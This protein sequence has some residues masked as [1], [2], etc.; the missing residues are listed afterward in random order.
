MR[1]LLTSLHRDLYSILATNYS[2]APT[3][4]ESFF[5]L[6][7]DCATITIQNHLHLPVGARIVEFKHSPI[8]SRSQL[9]KEVCIERHIWLRL[10]DPD[11]SK[12]A[13]IWS[14]H[15]LL[16]LLTSIPLNRTTQMTINAAADAFATEEEMGIGGWIQIDNTTFWFSQFWKRSDL[17]PYL[18][19]PKSLQRYITSWETLAQLCILLLVNKK[20]STRPGIISIQ[21]GSDTTGAEANI[22]HGFS[23]TEVLADIIKLV[24]LQQIRCNTILNI[25]HI[26]GEKNVD[27]DD[28]SPGRISKIYQKSRVC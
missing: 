11:A 13:L 14:K 21:S 5:E 7:N 28:L 4:W 20:C 23:T 22:N 2:I 10:R 9:P 12:D 18:T 16:P 1:F 6:L 25:H 27:A 17:Q 26:P 15:S 19:R 8:S 24:S 3:E